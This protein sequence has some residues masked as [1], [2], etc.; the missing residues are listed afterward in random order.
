MFK[1]FN[2]KKKKRCNNCNYNTLYDM[3]RA[4]VES[5]ESK[6][7]YDEF[8]QSAI[9]RIE[10]DIV[11]ISKQGVQYVT[12]Y[13]DKFHIHAN[14]DKVKEHF[15]SQGF[16]ITQWSLFIPSNALIGPSTWLDAK[17]EWTTEEK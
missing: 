7:N 16:K 10:E 6:Y 1:L 11:R 17:I 13:N 15:I 9:N 4:N 3:A 14:M 2:N 12:Y 8:T 5:F